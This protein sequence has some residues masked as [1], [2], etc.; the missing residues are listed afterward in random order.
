[1]HNI[2]KDNKQFKLII[3]SLLLGL[4]SAC[5]LTKEDKK[6]VE[7]AF[8]PPIVEEPEDTSVEKENCETER[9]VQPSAEVVKK[10][11]LVFVV[12]T[13]GSINEERTG[14]ANGIDAFVRELPAD[15]DLQV[16]I[17]YAH[18]EAS[19]NSGMLTGNPAILKTSELTIEEIR[20]HLYNRMNRPRSEFSSDGGEVGMYAFLK[21]ITGKYEDNRAAG[22]YRE[23][24]A[25]SV[26]FV[27]D[28]NDICAL[29]S[30]PTG[31]TPV[32][33]PDRL[34][35]PAF[36]KYCAG[37]TPEAIVSRVRDIKGDK[38]VLIS[39]IIYTG[40]NAFP[41]TGENEI[42]YGYLETINLANG[43]VIDLA[44]GQYDVSMREIG[45]LTYKKL[46]LM[47]EFNL[48]KNGFSNDSIE[49]KVDSKKT[50]FI[51]AD[52]L[53]QV[54]INEADAGG[55]KSEVLVSYCFPVTIPAKITELRAFGISFTQA[56]ISWQTD[57]EV[58]S[59][60]TINRLIDGHE[61][62][63]TD[64]TFKKSHLHTLTGLT[65][66]K[67]YKVTVTVTNKDG[68]KTSGEVKFK[69]LNSLDFLF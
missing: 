31:V 58:T 5:E 54:Q 35:Y 22:F 53:N 3:L 61:I 33:D 37:V 13:S 64:N 65:D 32:Y 55:E 6:N 39:G 36:A 20:A 19:N 66:N 10:L 50:N 41:K 45:Y 42:G 26:V 14:I 44:A 7:D 11:D 68:A 15:V 2:F 59:V 62:V 12:D 60:I 43:L 25:L 67:M 48:S 27:A 69:T 28:E 23:D 51:Y 56:K 9:F 52:A 30:Y 40:E 38:P 29:D 4:L 8:T 16:G 57:Q 46:N 18:G 24:A 17:M 34:E 63:I 21:S 47:T 49:V 1:M